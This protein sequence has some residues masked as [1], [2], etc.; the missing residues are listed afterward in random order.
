M[1]FGSISLLQWGRKPGKPPSTHALPSSWGGVGG[2]FLAFGGVPSLYESNL[3]K[4]DKI[5]KN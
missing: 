5:Q 1:G 2:A 4:N 3:K